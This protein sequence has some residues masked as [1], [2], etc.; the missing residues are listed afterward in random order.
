MLLATL[1]LLPFLNTPFTIDDPIYLREAQHALVEPLHPQAFSMVWS[2]DL[3]L[4]ASQ[5]LPG[6]VA[7]A[8]LLIPTALAGCQ[9]WA[10]HLTQLIL[11][12]AA[13]F[14]VALL[15]LRLGMDHRQARWAALLTAACPAVLGM[16][17]TVMPDVPAMLFATLGM[18]RILAWGDE[19]KWHQALLAAIW[20]ALAALTR[21]HTLLI[22]APALVLLL[23]RINP[24]RFLPLLLAPLLFFALATLTADPDFQGENILGSMLHLPGGLHLL[25]QNACAFLAHWLLVIPLTLPWLVMRFRRGPTLA[26]AIIWIAA[27]VT[28]S[29]VALAD[30]LW[31]AIQRRDR[32]QFALWLWLLL[33]LPAIFYIHLPSKY[34]LPSV[35]AA[36]ILVVRQSRRADIPWLVP[37]TALAGSILGLLILLGIRDLAGTQRRAV[38][39]LV[40]PHVKQEERVWFAGHWG[41]QWYAEHAGASP[42]TLVPPQPV[43]GDI[44]VVSR[45]DLPRFP[46]TWAARTVLQTV[47]YPTNGLGRV[48][49]LHSRAGFFSSIYGYLPWTPGSGDDNRFEV[50]RVT[51]F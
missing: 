41:F 42:V 33:A 12:L 27:A 51:E 10:G 45:I 31:D 26:A 18:E 14:A 19:Q 1:L 6:G 37:A 25:A 38:T 49:D 16:A 48:M 35:P 36:V 34:L 17:G 29:I 5:I 9:E 8:Y 11:L 39:D 7:A 2:T 50:W 47:S 3:N 23:N 28:A 4:R 43:P 21:T 24:I 30:I 46:P 22:L 40:A 20:L 32:V 13:L 15:A 44:I